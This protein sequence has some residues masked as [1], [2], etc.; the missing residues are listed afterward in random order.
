M[1]RPGASLLKVLWQGSRTWRGSASPP[2]GPP[3]PAPPA[4]TPAGP[5]PPAGTQGIG[6]FSKVVAEAFEDPCVDAC[7]GDLVYVDEDDAR[8]R[9]WES[10]P[11]DKGR[12]RWGWM[13]LHPTFFVRREMYERYGGFDLDF[14]ISADHELMFRFL[15]VHISLVEAE[16][17]READ[18][19]YDKSHPA[20]LDATWADISKAR[21]LLDWEPR[22]SLEEGVRRTV[23]WHREHRELAGSVDLGEV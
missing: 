10:G 12:W 23:E 8:V 9:Y 2:T 4:P 16:V 13:P 7:Y 11:Y 22:V 18:V 14:P 21:S 1:R 6:L 19:T 5:S 20:D 3:A 17:G 15:A